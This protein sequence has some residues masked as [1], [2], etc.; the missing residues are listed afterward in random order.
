MQQ[1]R[2]FYMNSTAGGGALAQQASPVG[3][4]GFFLMEPL[5]QAAVANTS[6]VAYSGVAVVAGNER[7]LAYC[8]TGGI[9]VKPVIPAY[10]DNGLHCVAASNDTDWVIYMWEETTN[11]ESM[12]NMNPPVSETVLALAGVG[13]LRTYDVVAAPAGTSGFATIVPL[14]DLAGAGMHD[15]VSVI[16]VYDGNGVAVAVANQMGYL[17]SNANTGLYTCPGKP[18][19]YTNGVRITITND[20]FPAVPPFTASDWAV[21]VWPNTISL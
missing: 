9:H 2:R 5:D 17:R 4:Q 15:I 3:T 18:W 21:I 19:P 14:G 20:N 7:S 13:G 8:T 6:I 12:L 10:F 1:P 16:K 11:F